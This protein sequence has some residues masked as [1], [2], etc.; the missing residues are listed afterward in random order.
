M[1]RIITAHTPLG[2]DALLFKS[3]AG[4]EQ[5]SELYEFDVELLSADNA[6]DLKGLL[7]KPL[8][9]EIRS[10]L[11]SSRY[12]NG[13]ITRM[14]L[15][16][17]ESHGDRYYIYRATLSPALWYL[18]QNRDFRIWQEKSVPE[19]LTSLLNDYQI[20]FENQLSA[21]YRQWGYCVQYNESD[22]DF[23]SRLMQHEGIYFWFRHEM[24]E[25]TL[26]LSDSPDSH[27][28]MTGYETIAYDM[29]EG[30]M[31][32]KA[33]GIYSWSVTDAITPGLYS[34]ADYDFH[35]PR[36]ALFEAR[37]NP[38]SFAARKAEVYDWPGRFTEQEH[39]QFYARVRQQEMEARHEQMSGEA[40]AVGIAPGYQFTFINP[41]RQEDSG[42]YLTVR[43]TYLLTENHYA[44]GGSQQGEHLVKFSVVP[45]SLN[46]RPA[47]STPWPRTYGPQT[48]EVVG[49]QGE[50]IWTDKYGRVKV[51]F[52][53]DRYA[54]GDDTSSCWVRVSSAWAGWK[55]GGV[56]VPRVGEEVVVDFINGDPDRP[57][58]TGRVY[59]EDSMPPWDLPNDATK[60][61][62]MS[63][64]KNGTKD[65]A[66]YL[67]FEDRLG[68][69][70]FDMHAEK[71]MNVSVENDKRVTVD[72]NRFTEI[73]KEQQDTVV[74]NATFH[75]KAKRDTTVD[76]VESNTFNNSQTTKIKNGRKLEITS[77]GDSNIIKGDRSINVDGVYKHHV[78]GKVTE[79]F[80]DG[81]QTTISAGGKKEKIEGEVS[82][83]INGDWN[84]TIT[85]GSVKIY[86]PNLITIKS[87]S[88]VFIDSPKFESK[89]TSKKSFAESSIEYV[90][91]KTAL[92]AFTLAFKGVAFAYAQTNISITPIS[93]SHKS[94]E[95]KYSAM[96]I[97]VIGTFVGSGALHYSSKILT[98]MI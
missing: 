98:L 75:Y 89:D 23:I 53:W 9:V 85:G 25:Q 21:E 1:D 62:F 17:R 63:R 5:L 48:A 49:P 52:R 6:I 71:D 16:G 39:G 59:N 79:M 95:N 67:F 22:Y 58:I 10:N 29:P 60:M 50:P 80:D 96:D 74:G 69:E 11:L 24:G 35:K 97:R 38:Q 73:N 86:S 64:S 3:L 28:T 45:A 47:R 30:D 55:Y 70:S 76:D 84:Q 19:I 44:S 4:T 20:T 87:D 81:L 66:S 51:K 8:T 65:N 72:G 40:T 31:L 37:Q 90:K 34:H 61:G 93:L 88:K 94:F 32:V 68:S 92:E 26:I 7:G 13:Y 91:S 82:I 46:W 27:T 12:L 83:D 2:S 54:S 57:I 36:A 41:P 78:T 77:G 56:Q 33:E 15:A 18:K 42:N 43:A 14:T